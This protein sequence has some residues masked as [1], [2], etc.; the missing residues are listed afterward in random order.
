MQLSLDAPR[1]SPMLRIAFS[2]SREPKV[3]AAAI[4]LQIAAVGKFNLKSLLADEG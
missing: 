2:S 3:R 4:F 1:I